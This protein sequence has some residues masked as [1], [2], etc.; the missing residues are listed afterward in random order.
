MFDF[1]SGKHVEEDR[2][3]AY[4]RQLVEAAEA[5]GHAQAIEWTQVTYITH[6][7]G[8]PSVRRKAA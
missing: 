7:V 1:E 5:S 6:S 8:H 2:C 3:S 4:L